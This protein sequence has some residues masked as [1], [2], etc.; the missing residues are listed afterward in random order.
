MPGRLGDGFG[1][2]L[3]RVVVCHREDPYAVLHGE[4][5]QLAG[6]Q[7]TVG[8]RGM[9]VEVDP[10]AGSGA[11]HQRRTLDGALARER[12]GRLVTSNP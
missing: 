1:Q 7:G 3:G 6:A 8:G 4:A 2:P 11:G 10:F 12:R 9:R 5:D